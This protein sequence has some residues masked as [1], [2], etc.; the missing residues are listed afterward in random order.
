MSLTAFERFKERLVGKVD[1][2]RGRCWFF[3]AWE[4]WRVIDRFE[5]L[6]VSDCTRVGRGLMQERSC[7]RCGKTQ[8]HA[9][10][11]YTA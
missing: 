6:R 10:K 7:S 9:Q 1:A 2:A 8:Q 4:R 3:H 11:T 5:I